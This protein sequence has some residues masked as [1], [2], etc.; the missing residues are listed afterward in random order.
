MGARAD[1]RPR[2]RAAL[3]L[4][5]GRDA[6]V[7]SHPLPPAAKEEWQDP[8]MTDRAARCELCLWFY[9]IYIYIYIL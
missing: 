9:Y 3:L 1:A 4:Q 2:P 5:A 7:L 8:A 6:F